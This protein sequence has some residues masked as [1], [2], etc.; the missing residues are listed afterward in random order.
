MENDMPRTRMSLAVVAT[1][2][3]WSACQD[4]RPIVTVTDHDA[5]GGMGGGVAGRGGDTGDAGPPGGSGGNAIP[6]DGGPVLF[7]TDGS[8]T[9]SLA[10]CPGTGGI[11]G[12]S[13]T[14]GAG[15]SGQVGIGTLIDCPAS[16]PSGA[17]SVEY[18]NCEYPNT[19]C[20]CTSKAWTCN[21][22]P[23]TAQTTTGGAMCRYGNLTCS[24]WGCGVCPDAH[25]T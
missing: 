22:C 8:M 5:G 19:S 17:C 20:R 10:A 14:A 2:L 21:A 12:S 18:M 16:P 3:L 4:G 6:C 24:S 1:V 25:P 9:C 23:A 7:C 15:G 13:G 11:G